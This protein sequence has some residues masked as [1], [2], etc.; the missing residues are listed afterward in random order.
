M[1][2]ML[3]FQPTK[4]R[5]VYSKQILHSDEGDYFICGNK[6]TFLTIKGKKIALGICYESLQTEHF[7]N[8]LKNGADVYIASVAKAEGG[9]QKAYK[10]FP[11]MSKEYKTPILMSNC[12]GNCDNF[13]SIGQSAVWNVEGQLM[14]QLDAENQGILI[15]D[16]VAKT[17]KTEQV[18]IEKGPLN[19]LKEL[20]QIYKNAKDVLEQSGI[21]QWTNNY[22]TISLI[23]NDLRKGVLYI[24]KN[25]NEIIG[26]INISEEQ[27]AE[28]DKIKWEFKD[29]KVLV[30]H[31]LV[32]EPKSQRM[33]YAQLLMDYAE[34]FAKEKNYTSIRLDAYSEN[35]QIIEFYKWRN[36]LIRGTV[37][38]PERK[39]PFFC[40]EKEI[41]RPNLKLKLEATNSAYRINS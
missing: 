30:I 16:T 14:E 4:E 5:E 10:H 2:S 18:R 12:V 17:V 20:F 7:T 38:F 29:T 3:I 8:A 32:I 25:K 11:K 1:I 22:P 23:E 13:L 34:N 6:Q 15:Y 19:D 33:G 36:Y 21:Y 27:E 39:K 37:H 28:Y 41:I 9:I 31:R 26:A 24:L 40:M 35:E